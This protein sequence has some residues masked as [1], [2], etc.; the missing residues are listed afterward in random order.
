M[1]TMLSQELK[2]S[3]QTR[4]NRRAGTK[5]RAGV[6]KRVADARNHRIEV[7]GRRKANQK[8]LED[9]RAE[10]A[11]RVARAESILAAA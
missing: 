5:S 8:A 11:V 9:R 3:S 1:P 2:K 7:I 10:Q 6:R 4:K